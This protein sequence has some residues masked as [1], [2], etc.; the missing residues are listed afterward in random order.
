MA[1]VADLLDRLG[2]PPARVWTIPIPGTADEDDLLYAVGQLGRSCELVDAT[3][4]EKAMGSA[5]SLIASYLIGLLWA[6]LASH[7]LGGKVLAPDALLRVTGRQVR[8]PDVSY[9]AAGQ[10]P[11]GVPSDPVWDVAPA[12]AVE[13]VSESNT[14]AEMRRKRHEY[15]S[16][17]TSIVWIVDPPSRTVAVYTA[18]E[19]FTTLTAADRLTG[20]TVLP[21]FDVAV[22]DVFRPLDA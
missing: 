6:H 3:L 14:P 15:F 4:V 21:G 17:G 5:E 18:P 20:G 12:L 2:V 7:K 11:N 16:G 8:G 10:L 9:I 13:V 22:A 19:Q 1:T